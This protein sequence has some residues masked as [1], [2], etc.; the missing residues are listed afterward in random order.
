MGFAVLA[1]F[2]GVP[3]L[4]IGSLF[5]T[6]LVATA[7]EEKKRKQEKQEEIKNTYD[8]I[9]QKVFIRDSKRETKYDIIDFPQLTFEKWLSFY[10]TSPEKWEIDEDQ[11][12]REAYVPV[13]IDVKEHAGKNGHILK[14]E[15]IIPTFW[16]SPE[17]MQKYVDWVNNE[18]EHGTV[19]LYENRRDAHS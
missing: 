5:I 11:Y 15:T 14:T 18:Y 7:K 10:N 9:L 16:A 13:Y 2:V 3:A 4:L 6:G 12:Y 8:R 17:D 1:I 19:K